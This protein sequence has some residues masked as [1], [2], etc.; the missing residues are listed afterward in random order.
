[1]AKGKYDSKSRKQGGGSRRPTGR[2]SVAV[3]GA[4]REHDDGVMVK[5][6]AILVCI[7]EVLVTALGAEG[8]VCTGKVE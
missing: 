6:S 7:T 3:G 2:G 4:F 1:M 8:S 5:M